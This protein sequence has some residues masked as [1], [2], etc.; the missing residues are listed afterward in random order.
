[1]LRQITLVSF[2]LLPLAACG[3]ATGAGVAPATTTTSGGAV[4][5]AVPATTAVLGSSPSPAEAAQLTG[6]Q[7]AYLT[8]V[9]TGKKTVTFDLVA[10]FEGAKAVAACKADGVTGGDSDWCTG[11]YFRNN[12]KKLRTLPL[13]PGAKLRILDMDPTMHFVAADLAHFQAAFNDTHHL[14]TFTVVGGRITKADEVYTP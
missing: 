10:W 2:L 14:M 8:A 5:S 12:S 6:A 7:W 11:Y 3:H 9:D 1:M 13:E 4:P